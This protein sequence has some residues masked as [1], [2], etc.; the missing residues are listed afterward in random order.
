MQ[1]L[2]LPTV[3]TI[4]PQDEAM[5]AFRK[6]FKLVAGCNVSA[7]GK[8]MT[9]KMQTVAGAARW[10]SEAQAIITANQLPLKPGVVAVKKDEVIVRVELRIVYTQ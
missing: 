7:D 3:A 6:L 8:V 10:L 1:V 2:Q 4:E 5:D 9:Y